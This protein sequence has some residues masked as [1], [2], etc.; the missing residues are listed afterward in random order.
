MTASLKRST[1]PRSQYRTADARAA[2]D[3]AVVLPPPQHRPGTVT[4]LDALSPLFQLLA[5]FSVNGDGLREKTEAAAIA[6]TALHL[7]P[8]LY[9]W[10]GTMA[11]AHM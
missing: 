8:Y 3:R 9:V 4:Q 10:V 7:H 6:A 1:F 2:S 5:I 11:C